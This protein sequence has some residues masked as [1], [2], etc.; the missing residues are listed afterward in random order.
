MMKFEPST[1]PSTIGGLHLDQV[2][3]RPDFVRVCF[4]PRTGTL[5]AV[6]IFDTRTLFRKLGCTLLG[7]QSD[8]KVTEG[9]ERS[10]R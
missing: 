6:V 10:A 1:A 4:I 8:K 2:F 5:L 7:V 3:V 9:T